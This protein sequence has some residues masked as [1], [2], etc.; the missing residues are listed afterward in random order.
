MVTDSSDN[1]SAEVKIESAGDEEM[2]DREEV[3]EVVRLHNLGWGT[4]SIAKEL[5]ISRETVKKYIRNGGYVEYK[6][7]VCVGVLSGHSEW[8]R[9]KF[10][11]HDGNAD[12]IRQELLQELGVTVSL[13]TV[14]REVKPY[15]EELQ[16]KSVATIRYETEPGE[17]MQIDFGE[18]Y[19]I[20]DSEKE[21]VHVFVAVLG[22]SRRAFVKIFHREN[23]M[24]WFAGLE[25]AFRYFGG[26]P[27]TVLVDN[28]SSLVK[29]HNT[30]TGELI[31]NEKYKAFASYWGFTPK[32]C[33]PRRARTKGKVESSVKYTKK[34]CIAG[35]RFSSWEA[36]EGHASAWLRDISDNRKLDIYDKRTP[37][38]LFTEVEISCL[39]PMGG[40]PPFQ[41]VREYVRKISKDSFVDI[42]T[43]RYSVPWRYIGHKVRVHVT[44]TE[45]VICDEASGDILAA[46]PIKSGR[47]QISIIPGHL[48]GIVNV[49]ADI[50]S[51]TETPDR[52]ISES[53]LER[54]LSVYEEAV[55]AA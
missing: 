35:R 54:P 52:S 9:E 28:A 24:T 47:R 25:E 10:F 11:Q 20:I 42:D 26:V 29:T 2:K 36:M 51:D 37:L 55:S 34:N 41:Q 16:R 39:V 38:E 33:K 30:M 53:T 14:E 1:L 13:R 4:R 8:V 22:Y 7:P 17:Q 3:L 27:R 43:N 49:R 23:Q 40:R 15:R 45:I 32:A 5:E 46:H 6:S 21:Y 48:K 44:D 18:R 31:F 19:V 50:L 12:V